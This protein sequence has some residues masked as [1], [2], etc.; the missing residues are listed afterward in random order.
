MSHIIY[1]YIKIIKQDQNLHQITC[2][3]SPEIHCSHRSPT[4]FSP[5]PQ[6]LST[7]TKPH[8]PNPTVHVYDKSGTPGLSPATRPNTAGEKHGRTRRAFCTTGRLWKRPNRRRKRSRSRLLLLFPRRIGTAEASGGR[9]KRRRRN[10]DGDGGGDGGGG[11]RRPRG[12]RGRWRRRRRRR[13][14]RGRLWRSW[15][16][17]L[18]LGRGISGSV[19]EVLDEPHGGGGGGGARE[20]LEIGRWGFGRILRSQWRSRVFF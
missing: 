3:P 10:G 11:G 14:R 1:N 17:L 5:L 15:L 9:E 7:T 8:L 2:L 19:S 6:N 16:G 4:I 20:A 12:R 13:G 18:G